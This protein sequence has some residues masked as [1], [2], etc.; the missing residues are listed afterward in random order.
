[1]SPH[2][3]FTQ[4]TF[5]ARIVARVIG[6]KLGRPLAFQEP[7]ECEELDG[8]VDITSRVHI[9]VGADYLI[10]NAW[11]DAVT[12]KS[13]PARSNIPYAFKDL[14]EALRQCPGEKP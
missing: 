14:Q 1:M 11:I 12:L 2:F 13:W 7:D 5:T 10:V 4:P 8:C 6:D 9:Q 3:H